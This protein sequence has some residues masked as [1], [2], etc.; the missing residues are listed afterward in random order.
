MN[1]DTPPPPPQLSEL[2]TPLLL[3]NFALISPLRKPRVS[4]H[5]RSS[6]DGVAIQSA[7]VY[8]TVLGMLII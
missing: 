5:G 1:M 7:W 3:L 6:R 8:E 4:R 2:V